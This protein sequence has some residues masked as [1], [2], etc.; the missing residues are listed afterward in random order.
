M[1]KKLTLLTAS[2]LMTLGALSGAHASSKAEKKAEEKVCTQKAADQMLK[3]AKKAGKS[4]TLTASKDAPLAELCL[5]HLSSTGKSASPK[6]SSVLVT[7]R[8]TFCSGAHPN[9]TSE[10]CDEV[11]TAIENYNAAG[12][13]DDGDPI[14]IS[15]KG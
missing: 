5:D 4:G 8:G 7:Y 13:T 1:V 10:R 15:V 6:T 14:K 11:K 3:A 2:A 12:H 9:F